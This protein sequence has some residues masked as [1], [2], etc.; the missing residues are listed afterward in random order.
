MVPANTKSSRPSATYPNV[1]TRPLIAGAMLKIVK[2]A[3]ADAGTVLAWAIE[4]SRGIYQKA[5]EAG[6]FSAGSGR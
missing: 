5:T 2:S 3:D 1:K 4:A 6:D